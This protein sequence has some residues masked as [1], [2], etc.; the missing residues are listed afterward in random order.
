LAAYAAAPW[1]AAFFFLLNQRADF[2]QYRYL[3][4][5]AWCL[6][7][8][9]LPL[10]LAARRHLKV[11]LGA[12]AAGLALFNLLTSILL[13]N[14]WTAPG[15]AEQDGQMP[16]L[17]PALA[18]LRRENIAH[19]F[20]A[21]WS[22]YRITFLADEKIICSQ[23]W[24]ER[25]RG[26]PIPY[27]DQV[28]RDPRAAYVLTSPDSF[29]AAAFARDMASQRI[30]SRKT[31]AGRYTVFD[32]F[33]KGASPWQRRVAP[34]QIT[35][36]ASHNPAQAAWLNDGLPSTM[37][38][39]GQ[40]QKKGMWLEL[41]LPRPLPLTRLSLH[42]HDFPHDRAQVL[43]LSY[44]RDGQWH[45]IQAHIPDRL[46][47]FEFHNHLPLYGEMMQNIRF[48]PVVTDALRLEIVSPRPGR[49]WGLA[50]VELFCDSRLGCPEGK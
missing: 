28:A 43:S 27:K 33:V 6:P 25:F 5:L 41:R 24:N 19:C 3:L 36:A 37:W 38:K 50:E 26:W 7:F 34:E 20:A 44:R 4:A 18:F 2:R 47:V 13:M 40:V 39:S 29:D 17:A 42:Y 15:F 12:L 21:H 31:E 1:V 46:Q 35:L 22:A 48:A 14:A 23:P 30:T 9:L 11:L 16:D 49:Y 32:R 8:L 10:C 45:A